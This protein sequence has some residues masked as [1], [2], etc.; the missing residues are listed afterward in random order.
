MKQVDNF[1]QQNGAAEKPCSHFSKFIWIR[2]R[3]FYSW[4]V[5]LW[6]KN[7]LIVELSQSDLHCVSSRHAYPALL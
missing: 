7:S 1:G 5:R 6:P 3:G 4:R 2:T